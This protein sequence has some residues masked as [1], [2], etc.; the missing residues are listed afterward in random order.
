M[1][2][3]SKTHSFLRQWLNEELDAK[4]ILK[5]AEESL[6][7]SQFHLFTSEWGDFDVFDACDKKQHVNVSVPDGL[8]AN[9][10]SVRFVTCVLGSMLRAF[11]RQPQQSRRHMVVI[12]NVECLIEFGSILTE[13]LDIPGISLLI[14][15][16]SPEIFEYLHL[17]PSLFD[18]EIK[19]LN[20]K[21]GA[22]KD[23]RTKNKLTLFK[24]MEMAHFSIAPLADLSAYPVRKTAEKTAQILQQETLPAQHAYQVQR[25]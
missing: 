24:K 21:N 11:K 20:Q 3:S 16:P 5:S 19:I 14:I 12:E 4:D 18:R 1:V 10:M 17:N 25:L 13:I 6:F 23:V 7:I 15:T 8:G 22:G 2:K 9:E